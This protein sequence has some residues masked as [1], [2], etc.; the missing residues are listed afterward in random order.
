MNDKLILTEA[1]KNFLFKIFRTMAN[2]GEGLRVCET[3][4]R[5][6]EQGSFDDNDIAVLEEILADVFASNNVNLSEVN[7]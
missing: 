3:C 7:N 1:Q 4:I 2:A 5:Y 6:I